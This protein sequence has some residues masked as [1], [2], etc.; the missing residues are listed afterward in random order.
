M[1]ITLAGTILF[2]HIGVAI[3]AFMIAG[4]LHTALQV[5]PRAATVQEL[6]AWGKVVHRLE[7]LFPVLA[8][9]LLGLG[10]WLV[11]LE[12]DEGIGWSNGW[13][14]TA[15]VTLVIV[16]ALGGILLAPR[17]KAMVAAI[18]AAANG[19][20]PDDIRAKTTDP[21][22][23]HV[24]HLSTGAF[25][26]VVFVMAA[27]PTGLGAVLIVLVGAALGVASAL[28]QLRALPVAGSGGVP[29]Q[30]GR[31]EAAASESV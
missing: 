28:V 12:G 16:E 31:T 6:R 23:W 10:A 9:V 5:M 13:V 18:D 21:V 27:K 2:L 17:G 22:L 7:P 19:P 26:G 3:S 1:N 29:A 30:R 14:I 8:L 24:A 15:V 11:H 20:V 25:L 4:V